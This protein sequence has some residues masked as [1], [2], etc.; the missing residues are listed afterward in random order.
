MMQVTI[1]MR[2]IFSL[3]ESSNKL[4]KQFADTQMKI[5]EHKCHLIVNTNEPTEIQVE[6]YSIE[7]IGSE[8]FLGVNIDRKVNLIVMLTIYAIKQIKN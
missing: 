7:S 3:Q 4:F 6:D 5:D 2:F 1:L 8:R